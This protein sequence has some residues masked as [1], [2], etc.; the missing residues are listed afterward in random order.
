MGV[1]NSFPCH[2]YVPSGSFLSAAAV[3]QP[4]LRRRFSHQDC[5]RNCEPHHPGPHQMTMRRRGL[6]RFASSRLPVQSMAAIGFE[7]VIEGCPCRA[8]RQQH[9]RCIDALS[10]F[11]NVVLPNIV[12]KVTSLC[13]F[14][15]VASG[16]SSSIETCR[17]DFEGARTNSRRAG[18]PS[19]RTS[20]SGTG[21]MGE[22]LF[23]GQ[24]SGIVASESASWVTVRQR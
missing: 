21:A 24:V 23:D 18:S 15:S 1:P 10:R 14:S 9:Y 3:R 4:G 13:H 6:F 12:V 11:H 16:R 5:P 8:R 7:A 17:G 2:A 20:C 22:S 19:M